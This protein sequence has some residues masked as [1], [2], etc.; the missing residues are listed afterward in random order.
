M[1]IKDSGSVF[2]RV[3][4]A[5][6]SF[7][8]SGNL[9]ERLESVLLQISPLLVSDFPEPMRNDFIAIKNELPTG[10]RRSGWSPTI[11]RQRGNSVF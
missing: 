1:A 5:M 4:N 3:H 9:G 10:T 8:R 6:S 2:E 7:C 11:L